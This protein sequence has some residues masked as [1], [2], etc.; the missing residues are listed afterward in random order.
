MYQNLNG[1]CQANICVNLIGTNSNTSGIGAKIKLKANISG[2]DTWQERT[3]SAQTGGG[4]GGQSELKAL[5]GLGNATNV[6]S[7]IVEWPSGFRQV[8]V[9]QRVDDC[10][11]IQEENAGEVCGIAFYD[12]NNNCIKDDDEIG[13][14]NIELNIQPGNIS[15]FTDDNG[16]YSISLGLGTYTISQVA[17]GNWTPSCPSGQLEQTVT[18]SAVGDQY[19]GLNFSESPTC[20]DPDLRVEVSTAAHRVG[21]ENMIAVYYENTGGQA[22][23]DVELTLSFDPNILPIDASIPWDTPSGNERIWHLGTLDVGATG[24]I[25][26]IDSISINAVL[27]SDLSV[28]ANVLSAEKDCDLTDNS[29]TNLSPAIGALDPNDILVSPEGAISKEEILTYKIRFQNVGNATVNRAIV[30]DQLPDVLD[31][32]TLE[33][34]IASDPYR[35]SVSEDG[36]LT[37]TFD[38]IQLPDSTTNELLSHGYLTFRIKLKPNQKVGTKIENQAN[39]FF[40]NN[41]PIATNTVENII[42]NERESLLKEGLLVY[43]NPVVD[44]ARVVLKSDFG[45]EVEKIY[46]VRLFN[47][48]GQ[49]VLEEYN[50]DDANYYLSIGNNVAGVYSLLVRD[51]NG[52]EY[53]KKLI[54]LSNG[55]II[56]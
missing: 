2:Q 53:A 23:T 56:S 18:V 44:Q 24:T 40:D 15:V 41:Q 51:A 55:E 8:L 47:A 25:Y 10:V 36:L 45:K 27:G 50:I 28:N 38:N 31:L 32:E 12:E 49:L 29:M 26:I 3:I 13:L 43:P 42:F 6:D 33:L 4:V 22:A 37:W 52:K 46:S 48:T 34:G 17:G 7:I 14:P 5:F 39:I 9:N 20:G 16:N 54:I 11:T 35:F 1:E 21:F 19:C 30:V